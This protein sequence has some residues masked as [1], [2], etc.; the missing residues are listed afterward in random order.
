MKVTKGQ[1]KRI[2]REAVNDRAMRDTAA[3]EALRWF[4]EGAV[5][6]MTR[7]SWVTSVRKSPDSHLIPDPDY[8]VMFRVTIRTSGNAKYRVDVVLDAETGGYRGAA[9]VGPWTGGQVLQ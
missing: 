5:G 1:L 3:E 7:D 6:Q 2:I 9:D 4:R 8:E